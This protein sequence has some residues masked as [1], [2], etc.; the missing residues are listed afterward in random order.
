MLLGVS[1]HDTHESGPPKSAQSP[2]SRLWG[3]DLSLTDKIL[4]FLQK[5]HGI[6]YSLF[7]Q[8]NHSDILLRELGEVFYR[9]CLTFEFNYFL[10]CCSPCIFQTLIPQNACLYFWDGVKMSS[11]GFSI[12]GAVPGAGGAPGRAFWSCS[13]T[14]RSKRAP[15]SPTAGAAQRASYPK[16]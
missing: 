15:S 13:T 3:P 14:S 8:L 2:A 5:C 6:D 4:R 11:S 9:S 1:S 10:S 16:S 7:P 12:G